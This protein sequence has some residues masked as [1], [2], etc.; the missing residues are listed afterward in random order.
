MQQT[1]AAYKSSSPTM[2]HSTLRCHANCSKRRSS[3]IHLGRSLSYSPYGLRPTINESS[4]TRLRPSS[5]KTACH[6]EGRL[7]E[8][9]GRNL[10]VC[11]LPG[12]KCPPNRGSLH[13]LARGRGDEP[14][15]V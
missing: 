3:S 6:W 10:A 15:K 2:W 5:R 12:N 9:S 11:R 7:T 8:S 14:P 4:K 13:G 1:R